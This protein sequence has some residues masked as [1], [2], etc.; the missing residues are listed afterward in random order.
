MISTQK[1]LYI[2]YTLIMIFMALVATFI[3]P[4]TWNI[5]YRPW[6]LCAAV[7]G[8]F[9]LS[10]L[11]G[12][13]PADADGY[14]MLIKYLSGAAVRMVGIV[15]VVFY[16]VWWAEKGSFSGMILVLC[17]MELYAVGMSLYLLRIRKITTGD[18]KNVN[19]MPK[20]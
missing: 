3:M 9:M 11:V 2:A 7:W 10:Y 14:K 15:A 4:E 1:N 13:I 8:V 16:P 20:T 17:V 18:K 5:Y 19:N 12:K 6:Q